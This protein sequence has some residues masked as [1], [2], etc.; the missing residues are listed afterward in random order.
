MEVIDFLIIFLVTLYLLGVTYKN[1]HLI[2]TTGIVF[3]LISIF[4]TGNTPKGT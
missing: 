1:N 4:Y 2:L 3:I